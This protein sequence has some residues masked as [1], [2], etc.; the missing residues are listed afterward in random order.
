MK[1]TTTNH[2]FDDFPVDSWAR[3]VSECVDFNF[4]HGEVGKVI[5]NSGGYLGI[6][7]EIEDRN[8]KIGYWGFNPQNLEPASPRTNL[9]NL[10]AKHLSFP[11]ENGHSLELDLGEKIGFL[12]RD[13]EAQA[14][15]MWYMQHKDV[16]RLSKI[17]A[18]AVKEAQG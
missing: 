11:L 16:L 4:F 12:I 18:R 8:G 3:I 10:A 15:A 17:L 13:D 14:E 7:L 2:T 9:K 5:R 1:I 6:R